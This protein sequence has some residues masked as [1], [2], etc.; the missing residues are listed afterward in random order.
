METM[1]FVSRLLGPCAVAAWVTM[2]AGCGGDGAYSGPIWVE[3][4]IAVVD[5][6]ADGRADVATLAMLM[7]G[8]RKGYLR[9]YRQTG[10][11]VFGRAR[12]SSVT[13]ST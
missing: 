9:V 4:D 1:G 12:R 8:G 3:T 10:A 6:D 11:E 7:G 5:I 13:T 2:L